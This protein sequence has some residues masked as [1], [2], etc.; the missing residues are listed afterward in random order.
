MIYHSYSLTIQNTVTYHSYSLAIQNT[1][2][3]HS[4]SITIQNTVIYHS[5]SLTI[6][7]LI[8]TTNKLPDNVQQNVEKCDREE[9]STIH[10]PFLLASATWPYPAIYPVHPRI[11]HHPYVSYGRRVLVLQSA[12]PFSTLRLC[13]DPILD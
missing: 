13:H 6:Q 4:Y 9:K 11:P 5:Y 3:Y 7:V 8:T 12:P 2:I 10:N 1:V